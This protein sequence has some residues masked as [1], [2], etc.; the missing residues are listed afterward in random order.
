MFGTWVVK[1]YSDFYSYMVD[2]WYWK[3]GLPNDV[4]LHWSLLKL[5]ITGQDSLSK[6]S[7]INAF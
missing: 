5:I 1:Q 3:K 2:N 7:W 6:L 4:L